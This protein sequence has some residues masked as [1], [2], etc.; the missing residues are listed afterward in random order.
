M[1]DITIQV[2][3][4]KVADIPDIQGLMR[5]VYRPP[6]FGEDAIWPANVLAMHIEKFPEGQFVA[7][8]DDGLLV[9]T[10]TSMRVSSAIAMGP[11]TW[12]GITDRGTISTHDPDGDVLYGVNI[13]VDPEYHDCGAASE[14]YDARFQMARKLG[15]RAFVAGARIPGYAALADQMPPDEYIE[16][17]KSGQLFDPTLSKQMRLG[18]TV[19]GL[20]PDY[21]PDPQTKN[22][23]ALI[24]LE[25]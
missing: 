8:L 6:L 24:R 25:L 7:V 10:S 12:A 22:Y 17:V 9:G 19:V 21:S 4:R 23:A 11:H 18:F 2:R 14:L 15:C 3:T 1:P 13:A 16:K 5:R 20:L